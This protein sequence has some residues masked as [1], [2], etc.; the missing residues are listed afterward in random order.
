VRQFS[1]M[2][3]VLL[4][5]FG[6]A[7]F[8]CAQTA[9]QQTG[10]RGHAL[11][12]SLLKELNSGSNKRNEDTNKVKLLVALSDNYSSYFPDS[13]I[14]FGNKAI[15][16]AGQLH[17]EKGLADAH[18]FLGFNYY[19]KSNYPDALEALFSALK[20]YEIL[21]NDQGTANTTRKIG[22]I[23]RDQKNYSKALDCY[24]KA[25]QTFEKTGNKLG[26]AKCYSNIGEIYGFENKF[27]DA[28][29]FDKKAIAIDEELGYKN[30]LVITYLRIGGAY[31]GNKNYNEALKNN[32]IAL[33]IATDNF[34]KNVIA[35]EQVQEAYGDVGTCY[36]IIARNTVQNGNYGKDTS[37][38]KSIYYLTKAIS[39]AREMG[40]LVDLQ[41]Y[42]KHL[43][44]AE[45]LSGDYKSAYENIW[46]SYQ[47]QDSLFSA[48]NNIK[49]TTLE[50]RRETELKEKIAK[51]EGVKK[52]NEAIAVVI[53]FAVLL[54]IVGIVFRNNKQLSFE[55]QKS[56]QLLEHIQTKNKEITDNIN[57]AQ[58]IQS[59]IL[60]DVELIYEAL[61]QSF[62]LYLPKDIVSGDFYAFAEKNDRL[63]VI[64]GDC[65]GHGVSGAFMSM[66]GS[67][68]LNQIINEK[69]IEEPALILNQLNKSVIEALKQG[70]NQSASADGMDIAICSFDLKK[71]GLAFAGANRPLWLV[72]NGVMEAYKPDKFPIGGLQ[73]A[74]DRTFTSHWVQLQKNDTIYIFTDGYADQF[75]GAHGKKL[76]TAKFKEMLLSI[77][78]MSMREQEGYL[79]KYFEEWK[80]DNEQVDDVLVIG[81]RV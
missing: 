30:G 2:L 42:Y 25:L 48:K 47:L 76:M 78:G 18:Y 5:S 22:T 69:G 34:D 79:K 59:A 62:I 26:I 3:L 50:T 35:I 67:S 65:T 54:I 17:W 11:I 40:E 21:A 70:E 56:E 16:L 49:I 27:T 61:Q 1:G 77:Q 28:I 51:L 41:A 29:D 9:S 57:Y 53:S 8:V 68:L 14:L 60:P 75:G 33:N 46:L 66:I 4:I 10:K 45:K 24:F 7:G 52:R 80:G 71:N 19:N 23:Y 31:L 32:L 72:R 64:A 20:S 38:Q 39:L 36:L 55:K 43:S 13:G 63:L 44:E 37:V 74:R 58:R 6:G 73:M 15:A 12:D 81:V